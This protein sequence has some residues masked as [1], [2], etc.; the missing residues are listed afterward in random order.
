MGVVFAIL[1]F[2]AAVLGCAG[3]PSPPAP[4]TGQ[5][6]GDLRLVPHEG[7]PAASG[8]GAYGDRRLR[9]V[10][11]VDYSQ[12]GFAVVYVDAET[13]PSGELTLRIRRSR[14]G[15]VVEPAEGA[16]GAAGRIVV[17]NRSD[18]S[19]VV[20]HPASGSVREV[21]AGERIE[22]EIPGP[23]AQQLYLL[24]VPA[25]TATI[26]AAPGPFVVVAPSGRFALSDLAPG[27]QTVHAWHPR[28]PPTSRRVDLAPDAS[29]R[30]DLELGVGLPEAGDAL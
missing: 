7:V 15:V 28:L 24:D 4:G 17:E 18:A 14:V 29:V 12:P 6:W 13:P 26:F 11:L 16:V 27:P 19:H 20:S 9:D 3:T 1:A 23:G 25:A 2:A 30:V 21:A 8:A 22:L 5:L 10:H